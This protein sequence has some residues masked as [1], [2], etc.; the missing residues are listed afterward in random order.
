[1]LNSNQ[2][3]LNLVFIPNLDDYFQTRV[4]G[5]DALK[6][7]FRVQ[8]LQIWRVRQA[9]DAGGVHKWKLH[10]SAS[11]DPYIMTQPRIMLKNVGY[12]LWFTSHSSVVHCS[13]VPN[14]PS[15]IWKKKGSELAI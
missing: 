13:V 6:P 15:L 1:M 12:D 9:D 8:V 10:D 14:I 2:P 11:I 3:L 4:L 5:L 7:G